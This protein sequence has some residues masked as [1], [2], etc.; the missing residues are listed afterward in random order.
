[1]MGNALYQKELQKKEL[2]EK[3][4]R[5]IRNHDGDVTRLATIT[6][7]SMLCPSMWV[8]KA[9]ALVSI[10][11]REYEKEVNANVSDNQ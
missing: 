4:L 3:V 10:C 8:S 9:I 2:M 1:M 5:F 6:Y 11:F 7:V